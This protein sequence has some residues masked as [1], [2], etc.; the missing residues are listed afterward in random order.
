MAASKTVNGWVE[1]LLLRTSG[2]MNWLQPNR[3]VTMAVA[4]IPGRAVVH[5]PH[6]QRD[7]TR[8][9]NE[10]DAGIGVH[11]PQVGHDAVK[12][13][14][15]RIDREHQCG[16]DRIEKSSL[17]PEVETGEGI[18]AQNRHDEGKDGGPG[19]LHGYV[20]QGPSDPSGGVLAFRSG[21]EKSLIGGEVQ[22]PRPPLDGSALGGDIR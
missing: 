4:A 17:Q 14:E 13:Y 19:R 16:N 9:I 2:K 12:R 5:A 20:Y 10:D 21:P 7:E 6:G 8:R 3:K 11:Q 22:V 18:G 15:G 1:L